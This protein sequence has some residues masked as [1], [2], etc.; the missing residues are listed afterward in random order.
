MVD[1]NQ[2]VQNNTTIHVKRKTLQ[3]LEKHQYSGQSYDGV[4]NEIINEIEEK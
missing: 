3:R 2:T 4:I 1:N